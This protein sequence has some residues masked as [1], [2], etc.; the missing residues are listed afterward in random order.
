VLNVDQPT[1]K[2]C[3]NDDLWLAVLGDLQLNLPQHAFNTWL[4]GTT[5]ELLS[6]DEIRIS[7]ASSF[8]LDWLER[9]CYQSIEKTLE[10]ITGKRYSIYFAIQSSSNSNPLKSN[11]PQSTTHSK[12]LS[13]FN[14]SY[15]FNTFIEGTKN[16]LAYNACLATASN[17]AS[18]YNPLFIYSDVGLGKTHLLH[19]IG[20][21]ASLNGTNI[22]FTT[23]EKFTNDFIF[24]IRDRSTEKF[25]E[26]YQSSQIL[27]IDDIQFISGKEQT[28]EGFFHIFN[29][30]HHTG[31]KIIITSDQAPNKLNNFQQRL[32]SRF[33]WGLIAD[34]QKPDLETRIAIIQQKLSM[35][36]LKLDT[37]IIDLI[38]KHANKNI[39]Q[40][41][42]I[43]NKLSAHSTLMSI[44]L[45]PQN[46]LNILETSLK[47]LRSASIT[48]DQILSAVAQYF[49]IDTLAILSHQRNAP[50]AEARQIVMYL[51]KKELS[52]TTAEISRFL[53]GR[54][55]STTIHGINKI[56]AAIELKSKTQKDIINIQNT[57]Y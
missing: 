2:D 37:T 35:L 44:P 11:T 39:R 57:L 23:G 3:N 51:L 50:V 1:L 28:Q 47:Q 54:N 20:N 38:A 8:A 26:S 42:G 48:S 40:I 36:D 4:K 30:L 18:P 13:P 29:E 6:H 53:G 9:R 24:S 32:S 49:K 22:K 7:V 5:A 25:K 31:T 43:I 41:E 27:L 19:A 14:S 55:H 56:Q 46:S 10:K 45:T 16:S 12:I 33:E 15:T 34:I 52:L 21:E 17:L